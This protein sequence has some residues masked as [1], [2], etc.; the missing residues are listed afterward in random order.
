MLSQARPQHTPAITSTRKA[1]QSRVAA[2]SHICR[3]AS[4]ENTT[5]VARGLCKP[6]KPRV[7]QA[8]RSTRARCA[9]QGRWPLRYSKVCPPCDPVTRSRSLHSIPDSHTTQTATARRPAASGGVGSSGCK[10]E[11][12]R[13]TRSALAITAITSLI[14]VLSHSPSPLAIGHWTSPRNSN[15]PP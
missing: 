11:T 10:L 14:R 8:G 7:Q 13:L 15:R 12:Q 2:G 1:W 9:F 3:P 4:S 5:P 6:A